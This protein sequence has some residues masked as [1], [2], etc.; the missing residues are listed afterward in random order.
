MRRLAVP[1]AAIAGLVALVVATQQAGMWQ[2]SQGEGAVLDDTA[3]RPA[4]AGSSVYSQ[5]PAGAPDDSGAG[6]SSGS[7]SPAQS[8]GA[9][10]PSNA[11]APPSPVP[12]KSGVTVGKG[13]VMTW[14]GAFG[15][16]RLQVIVPVRNGGAGWM[17]L[18]RSASRYRV[19]DARGRELASGMFT[20]ALPGVVAPNET[21]YLVET[22]SAAFV[23]GAGTPT[24]EANVEAVP[25]AQPTASLRVT[26]LRAAATP[27]GGLRVTGVVHNLG[28]TATDWLVAGG[29]LVDA[30]RRPLGAVYDPGRLEPLPA[31]ASIRFDT[32]YP[33]APAP[34]DRRVTL[35][36]FA[37]EALGDLGG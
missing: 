7:R 2:H 15:E 17:S 33:G 22:V 6:A 12:A 30:D 4:S 3:T 16:D 32:T 14:K 24:V 20:V 13:N 1:A 31:G 29:V 11:A 9:A 23:T 18:P 8:F 34:T 36:G 25:I 26:D 5:P 37:F 21:A 19:V 28:A 27:D 35:I 10:A